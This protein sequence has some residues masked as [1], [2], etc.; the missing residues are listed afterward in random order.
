MSERTCQF[1]SD[2][3]HKPGNVSP[4]LFVCPLLDETGITI[5][6]LLVSVPVVHLLYLLAASLT[7]P[8]NRI[9]SHKPFYVV[10]RHPDLLCATIWARG[11]F[12]Y[13]I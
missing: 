11:A 3:A 10:L 8:E 9:V 4:G 7:Q 1:D 2:F 12:E 6:G 13:A 5:F